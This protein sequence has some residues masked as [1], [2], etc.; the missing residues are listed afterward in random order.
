MVIS[1]VLILYEPRL[2]S[3]L[4]NDLIVQLGLIYIVE[5]TNAKTP[6][7]GEYLQKGS[8]II[9]G[10][11]NL[12]K[13]VNTE[14]T[15]GLKFIELNDRSNKERQVFFPKIIC[16]PEIAIKKQTNHTITIIPSKSSSLT[17]GKLA[18]EIKSYYFRDVDKE[19]KKW[20][21]I[22]SFD[23]ILLFLPSGSSMIKLD[24]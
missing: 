1:R 22:L 2:Y 10:K 8:F 18:K 15:I 13:N 21:E 6:P 16:G 24:A 17:A 23:E 19:L 20:L 9:S 14:L 11:K 12:I 5:V 4:I 7:S 3:D